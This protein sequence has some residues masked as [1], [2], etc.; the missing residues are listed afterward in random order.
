MA[1]A[2]DPAAWHRTCLRCGGELEEGFLLDRTD[3][4]Y[5]QGEWVD[6]LPEKSVWTGLKLKGRRKIPLTTYRCVACGRLD[7][8]ATE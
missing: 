7:F 4:G 6:G 2:S 1:E 3:S 5:R 8:F